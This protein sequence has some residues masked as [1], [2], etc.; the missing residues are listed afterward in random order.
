MGRKRMSIG[1]QDQLLAGLDLDT[2]TF[3]QIRHCTAKTVFRVWLAMTVEEYVSLIWLRLVVQAT[4]QLVNE[5][6]Q[7]HDARSGDRLLIDSLMHGHFPDLLFEIHPLPH[8]RAELFGSAPRESESKKDVAKG[9]VRVPEQTPELIIAHDP[10]ALSPLGLPIPNE[11]IRVEQLK[12]DSPIE[13]SNDTSKRIA[14]GR[15]GFASF[16]RTFHLL[17]M[18]AFHLADTQLGPKHFESA[19]ETVLVR[20][21]SIFSFSFPD[22]VDEFVC[23]FGKR[24][25]EPFPVKFGV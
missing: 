7:R 6:V 11:W 15:R 16:W 13:Y 12:V 14:D 2:S 19:K 17:E 3:A 23:Q 8:Q 25:V 9:R 10:C 24:G 21:C 18:E 20:R 1:I 22:I 5:G 4:A